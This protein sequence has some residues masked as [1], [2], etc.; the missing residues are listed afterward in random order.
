M[1]GVVDDVDGSGRAHLERAL[2]RVGR[3][4][5]SER[6]DDDLDAVAILGNLQGLLYGVL[7]KL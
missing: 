7:I 2:D 3:I 1:D 5:R 4:V 6:H